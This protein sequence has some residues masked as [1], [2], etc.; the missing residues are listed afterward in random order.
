[1]PKEQ[2]AM[3]VREAVGVF[4]NPETLQEAIDDLMSHGFDRAELSLLA[5]EE[6]I[7]EKLGNKYQKIAGFEDD[8]IVP[9]CCYI[10]TESIGDGR[11]PRRSPANCMVLGRQA[12]RGPA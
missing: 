2:E 7:D 10:S 6:T 5:G 11:L 12:S 3:A 8:P 4:D 1:M 9:R